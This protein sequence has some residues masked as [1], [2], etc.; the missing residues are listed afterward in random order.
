MKNDL[1]VDTEEAIVTFTHENGET[2]N[3]LCNW[4]NYC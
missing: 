3:F 4:Y 1:M 2:E